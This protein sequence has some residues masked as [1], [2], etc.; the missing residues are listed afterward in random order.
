MMVCPEC[1]TRYS[2]AFRVCLRCK[3]AG[4]Y[5]VKLNWH[6]NPLSADREG[7]IDSWENEGGR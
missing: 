5:P 2:N 6:S 7:R 3:D 4:G 1:G